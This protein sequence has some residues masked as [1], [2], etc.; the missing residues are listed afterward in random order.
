MRY[1]EGEEPEKVGTIKHATFTLDNLEFAAMDS[2]LKHDF[3]FNEAISLMV[4]CQDQEEIDYYWDKLSA[5][6]SAE[7]CGW[8]KDK[9]GMS[10][11]IVPIAMDEMMESDDEEAKARVTEAFLKMKKFDLAKLKLAY[12]G[13]SAV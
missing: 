6:P 8:L 11:Q 9:Y 10:W 7:Q 1:E 3:S 5:D 4:H 2:S 13:E 12:K